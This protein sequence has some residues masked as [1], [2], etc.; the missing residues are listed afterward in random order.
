MFLNKS[1]Y[2]YLFIKNEKFNINKIYF[3]F[4]NN[5][6]FININYKTILDLEGLYLVSPYIKPINNIKLIDNNKVCKKYILEIPLLDC[7]TFQ[8][9]FKSLDVKIF[10]FF[11]DTSNNLMDMNY[12]N[13]IKN[14]NYMYKYY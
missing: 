9:I 5:K 8:N 6:D 10:D 12:V 14:S 1:N 4:E 7:E 11:N 2:N 3:D 13:N